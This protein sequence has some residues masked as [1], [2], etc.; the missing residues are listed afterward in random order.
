[1]RK[2]DLIDNSRIL[3]SDVL[4]D[5]A[6]GYK[7]L[8]IATGY[9]DL[10]GTAEI[11]PMLKGYESIRLLIGQEPLPHRLQSKYSIDPNDP[12]NL[13]PDANV[14]HDLVELGQIGT[15]QEQQIANLRNTATTM[16]ELMLEG[17]LQVKVFRH[18]RLHA[19]AYI[20]GTIESETAIGIVGS[21]NFT[22]AGL[23][24]NA[25][26]NFLED[27]SQ[28]VQFR[29]LSPEQKQGHLSWF[30]ELWNDPEAIEWT[31]DFSQLIQDSPVGDLTFGPYDTYIKTLMQVFPDEITPIVKM[32]SDLQEVLY[33]FQNRNAGSLIKKLNNLGVAMLSDSVGLGKTI[34]AGAVIRHYRDTGATNVVIIAPASLKEQWIEDLGSNLGLHVNYDYTIVSQQDGRALEQLIENGEK[35]WMRPVDL[36]VVDEAHNL[37]SGGGARYET[38]MELFQDNPDSKVLLL[39]ATPIN[40]S[41]MDFSNQ[42]Q[43]G[44]KGSLETV[45]VPYIRNDGTAELIDFTLALKRIQSEARRAEKENRTFDWVKYKTTVA[46][47]LRRYLVRTTRKGVEDAGGIGDGTTFPKSIVKQIEYEYDESDIE[48]VTSAIDTNIESVFEEIPV[49]KLNLDFLSQLTQQTRHPFDL[50]K[51]LLV[52]NE[53][54][55]DIDQS[56]LLADEV[57]SEILNLFQ[58]VNLLGFVPYRPLLYQHKYYGKSL[59]EIQL[60]LKDTRNRVEARQV[61]TQMTVHN[62][63]H[64]TWLKRM[65]SS[66]AALLK[67][68]SNYRKRLNQFSH[69]LDKGIIVSLSDASTLD[70]EYG[71]DLEQAFSD[72]DE[73]LKEIDEA[74]ENDADPSAIKKRGIERRDAD[75]AVFDISQMKNDIDRDIQILDLLQQTLETLVIPESNAKLL[76]FADHLQRIASSE[77]YG[78]KILVFS[79]FA[80]TISYLQDSLKQVIK[81]IDNFEKRS[82]FISG[83]TSQN[84]QFTRRFAPIAKH[85]E[86]KE[87]EQEIDFLFA[88]DVLSEGQNLQDAGALINYDLHWNPVRMIQRNGRINRL[89][90]KY[91]EVLI[92]NAKPHTDLELYLK[93][94]RRLERKIDA[95]NNTIGLDQ[96]VLKQGQMNPMEFIEDDSTIVSQYY[97]DDP[98]KAS[99]A[100]EE[101][102]TQDDILSWTDDYVGDLHR[103]LKDHNDDGE[104]QRVVSIPLGKWN[105]LPSSSRGLKKNETLSLQRSVGKTSL[106]GAPVDETTFIKVD[107]TPN[108]FGVFRTEYLE[109]AVA[110][111]MIK[112]VPSDNARARDEI[113]VDRQGVDVQAQIL[114]K[115][116]VETNE[117]SYEWKHRHER[118]YE[119]IQ[120]GYD[121][122]LDVRTVLQRGIRTSTEVKEFERLTRAINNE[123]R[124]SGTVSV[125]TRNRFNTFF[126]SVQRKT[127][128]NKQVERQEAVLF[129]M[130]KG[131][132][133]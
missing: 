54:I 56:L 103:F 23:T 121:S 1:M 11:L 52:G 102:E 84:E 129:Y 107:T 133:E 9:W 113:K 65:E 45:L 106:T 114:A 13:F 122:S 124:E 15:G 88:T 29:P 18:P 64:V 75:F 81:G 87:Q 131:G 110:L 82:A 3:L 14:A 92:A 26:L 55:T 127:I 91:E 24:S 105:Y 36:F 60:L 66:S 63:M 17:I 44:L 90:S 62:I 31:G 57:G 61:R 69:Y 2:Y 119:A 21:S 89:G 96:D 34:T 12:E 76:A 125:V 50:L 32:P 109:D 39:T 67:S 43:L 116:H 38:V 97:S 41:L 27:Q 115:S 49:R 28:V 7:S 112:A 70:N 100:A 53:V 10:L 86:L 35:P 74:I 4:R 5:T 99:A 101:L 118:M 73:Y 93:L 85:Y 22:S 30:E 42:V 83:H 117:L 120:D 79:F 51:A 20:F 46:K 40:N 16:A 71:D 126:G 47:G 78:K 94:V 111:R 108:D 130:M 6:P 59:E 104:A 8:S 80:D 95:I 72:Y 98:V 58:V 48:W 68:V 77:Q 132:A 25:E 33:P 128:E 123:V 19:K 37:R